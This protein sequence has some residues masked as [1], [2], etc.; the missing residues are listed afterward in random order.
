MAAAC[1]STAARL[2]V[3]LAILVDFVVSVSERTKEE[4]EEVSERTKGEEEEERESKREG[5]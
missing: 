1:D 4:E 5:S 2:A 3:A